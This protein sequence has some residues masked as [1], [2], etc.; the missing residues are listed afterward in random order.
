MEQLAV[1]Q[2]AAIAEA[3]RRTATGTPVRYLRSLCT[4]SNSLCC[5]FEAAELASLQEV[6]DAAQLPYNRIAKARDLPA[7]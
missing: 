6:N 4:P 5:W 3:G 7:P 1:A 2:G